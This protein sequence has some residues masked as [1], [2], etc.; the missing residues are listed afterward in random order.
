MTERDVALRHMSWPSH[1]GMQCFR[2]GRARASK[3]RRA[4]SARSH[5]IT[6]CSQFL[7]GVPAAAGCFSWALAGA[8]KGLAPS[9]MAIL[10]AGCS[11]GR[12]AAY[13]APT[14]RGIT[15]AR[16]PKRAANR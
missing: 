4:A 9:L 14:A 10:P 11:R 13:S 15:L 8:R 1:A 2:V 12:S 6:A 5:G 16:C 3:S 7:I